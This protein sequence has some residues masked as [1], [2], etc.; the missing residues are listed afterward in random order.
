MRGGE[1]GVAHPN[2]RP[3]AGREHLRLDIHPITIK[4]SLLGGPRAVCG[5]SRP[6]ISGA[7]GI[8]AAAAD[9]QE[10]MMEIIQRLDP[11]VSPEGPGKHMRGLPSGAAGPRQTSLRHRAVCVAGLF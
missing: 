4:L 7:G 10:V 5:G 9:I 3:A 11:P 2:R 1:G 6:E 8:R